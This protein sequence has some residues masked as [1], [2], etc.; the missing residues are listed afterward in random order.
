MPAFDSPSMTD[1][2]GTKHSWFTCYGTGLMAD[3]SRVGKVLSIVIG[4][5]VSLLVAVS[6]PEA[7]APVLF[8][9]STECLACHNSLTTPLGRD[10]SIGVDWCG[11]MMANS[12]RDPYWQAAVR[13][14]V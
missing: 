4:A 8:E 14:E 12:A 6:S 10:V 2:S 7:Q 3:F 9:A 11:S 5:T 13:R 1:A